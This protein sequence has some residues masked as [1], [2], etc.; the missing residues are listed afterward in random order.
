[1]YDHEREDG[2]DFVVDLRLHLA[3]R[4]AA[5]SDDVADT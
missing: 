3:L 2:Q 5:A 1:M 4:A